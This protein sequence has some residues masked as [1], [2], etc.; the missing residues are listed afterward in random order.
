M[1]EILMR[2][3]WRGKAEGWGRSRHLICKFLVTPFIFCCRI[4]LLQT[5]VIADFFGRLFSFRVQKTPSQTIP[6]G[7]LL[8]KK[9]ILWFYSSNGC[10]LWLGFNHQEE[11]PSV[12]LSGLSE[13]RDGIK[14]KTDPVILFSSYSLHYCP[15][16]LLVV[17]A[18]LLHGLKM[19]NSCRGLFIDSH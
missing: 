12:P 7:S 4:I 16:S 1:S 5:E 17:S 18:C 11:G 2:R 6:C 15:F 3:S 19:S 8:T 9:W 14:F 13:Y 10:C